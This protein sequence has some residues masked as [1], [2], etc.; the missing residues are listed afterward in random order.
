MFFKQKSTVIF[1]NYESFGYL[2]DNRN[3]G[4]QQTDNTENLIGDKIISESGAVFLS[5]LGR[6]PH[7][8]LINL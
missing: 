8:H 4:Y 3:F 6:K 1:R 5:V 7:K 2:T